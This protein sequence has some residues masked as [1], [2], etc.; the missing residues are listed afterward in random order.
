MSCASSGGC[1][2]KREEA[3][4]SRSALRTAGDHGVGGCTN[5]GHGMSMTTRTRN[6]GRSL[7]RR[8]N[9]ATASSTVSWGPDQLPIT[10]VEPPQ[11]LLSLDTHSFASLEPFVDASSSLASTILKPEY[12][13]LNRRHLRTPSLAD[14][15]LSS[16]LNIRHASR[17]LG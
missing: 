6:L 11:R 8:A 3:D 10:G 15:L 4:R 12:S 2:W 5:G 17:L 13:S 9:Q 7:R 14:T 16:V 1:R